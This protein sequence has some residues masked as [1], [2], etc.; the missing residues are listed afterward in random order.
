MAAERFA[1]PERYSSADR[2]TFDTNI[3]FYSIDG[4]DPV[5]HSRARKMIGLA[6]TS[7]VSILLQT[8]GELSN[9][10]IKRQPALLPRVEGLIH[11]ASAMFS[12]VTTE[13]VDITEALLVQSEHKLQFWDAVL[14]A[15][16]RRAGCSTLF[17]ED[18]QDGRALGGVSIRNPFVMPQEELDSFLS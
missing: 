10:V 2:Y 18:V 8:L 17:S 11:T 13:F 7:R 14:W 15:T 16:S 1:S 3:L 12:V 4:R 5:K 6:D 9:A